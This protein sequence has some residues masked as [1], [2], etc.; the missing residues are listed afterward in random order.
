MAGVA[1][2]FAKDAGLL[3]GSLLSGFCCNLWD[4]TS[5][6]SKASPQHV[7]QARPSTTEAQ[8]WAFG[9]VQRV[10]KFSQGPERSQSCTLREEHP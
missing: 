3:Q 8:L 10:F 1:S 5:P 9:V 2:S 7:A 6:V 4:V